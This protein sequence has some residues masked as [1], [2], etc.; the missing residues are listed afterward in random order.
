M[1]DDD[2]IVARTRAL[3]VGWKKAYEVGIAGKFCDRIVKERDVPPKLKV[4]LFYKPKKKPVKIG[5]GLI[6]KDKKRKLTTDERLCLSLMSFGFTDK[7]VAKILNIT[8]NVV[9]RHTRK[10]LSKFKAKTRT[11]AVAI[12]I[13]E[14]EIL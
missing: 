8:P 12:A 14:N 1:K 10:I 5:R 3:V 2:P 9:N 6:F 4:A 13:R 11:Q 7:E